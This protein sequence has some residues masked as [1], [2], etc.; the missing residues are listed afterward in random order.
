GKGYR[1]A[2]DAPHAIAA[3]QYLPDELSGRRYYDPSDRGFEK[4]VTDRVA[5]IR[6]ILDDA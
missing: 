4:Q 3:Q 2:H 6:Q 1:Y 5:R